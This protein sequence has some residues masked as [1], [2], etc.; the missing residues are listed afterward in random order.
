MWPTRQNH[1]FLTHQTDVDY[2]EELEYYD[3]SSIAHSE[4]YNFTNTNFRGNH[5]NSI[6]GYSYDNHLSCDTIKA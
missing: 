1:H 6:N 5:A 4:T 3:D 2:T